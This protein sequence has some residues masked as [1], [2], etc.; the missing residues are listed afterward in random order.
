MSGSAMFKTS[1]M[2]WYRRDPHAWW[3]KTKDLEVE[4]VGVYDRLMEL[5]YIHGCAM[6]DDWGRTGVAIFGLHASKNKSK[7][8]KRIRQRLLDG[9]FIYIDES[10]NLAQ[11][12]VME[13]LD[14]QRKRREQCAEAGSKRRSSGL[15]KARGNFDEASSKRLA[16]S[17]ETLSSAQKPNKIN[18]A[19]SAPV[20]PPFDKNRDIRTSTSEAKAPDVESPPSL[21]AE[22]QSEPTPSRKSAVDAYNLV[23][24]RVG[25]ALAKWPLNEA[26]GRKLDTHLR[27]RG[28]IAG[29]MRDLAAMEAQRWTHG[30]A[31]RKRDH[32]NWKFTLT[33][34]FQANFRDR[35]DDF[36]ANAPAA[37][38]PLAL[39]RWACTKR[40]ETGRWPGGNQPEI[41]LAVRAEFPALFEERG[42]A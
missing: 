23:A 9:G 24:A 19:N 7:V 39:E 31:P 4:E 26:R 8:W 40:A 34:M 17:E 5:M 41:S 25:W 20:P 2:P 35:M 11:K 28:G 3:E 22:A 18:V 27:K 33:D 42:A 13:E 14:W 12:R 30:D 6:P 15:A 1:F 29:W 37:E 32:E 38:D 16:S 36:A 10:G 21:F